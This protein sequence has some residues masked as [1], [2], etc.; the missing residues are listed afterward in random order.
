ME[1]N[2]EDWEDVKSLVNA[3]DYVLENTDKKELLKIGEEG[4]YK[5][6]I[7]TYHKFKKTF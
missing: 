5:L 4:Y 7:I 1:F 3:A 2:I 6:V